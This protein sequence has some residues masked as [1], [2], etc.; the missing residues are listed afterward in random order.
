[1]VHS[2]RCGGRCYPYCTYLRAT[3]AD[4]HSTNSNVHGRSVHDMTR[5]PSHSEGVHCV[6]LILNAS[7]SQ[8]GR[9]V[10]VICARNNA[11]F[12]LPAFKNA[13]EQEL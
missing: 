13:R 7:R 10:V 2:R 4:F 6:P 3:D 5:R 1:M 12:P 11:S 8:I 9:E